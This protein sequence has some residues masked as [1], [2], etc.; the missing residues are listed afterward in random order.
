[1]SRTCWTPWSPWFV[2]W[3]RRRSPMTS[4]A[5]LS[6][7]GMD[8][9]RRHRIGGSDSYRSHYGSGYRYGCSILSKYG[10][11][12][13]SR[14]FRDKNKKKYFSHKKM[15]IFLSQKAKKN[16]DKGLLVSSLSHHASCKM[17]MLF[18][19]LNL[20]FCFILDVIFTPGSGIRISNTDPGPDPRKQFNN[21]Y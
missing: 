19:S 2:S 6:P 21:K 15:N 13:G 7:P 3:Q 18:S 8:G 20:L 9:T 14:F 10:C 17:V 4:F 16:F 12:F 5:F 11:G 1:M